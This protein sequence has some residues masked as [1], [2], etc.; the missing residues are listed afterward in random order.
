MTAKDDELNDTARRFGCPIAIAPE[1]DEPD[2][3]SLRGNPE[4]IL[5]YGNVR[6][7]T[8]RDL[9]KNKDPI[10]RIAAPIYWLHKKPRKE[11]VRDDELVIGGESYPAHAVD[12]EEIPWSFWGQVLKV[13]RVWRI[14]SVWKF[15]RKK[16][17]NRITYPEIALGA[18][19]D[20]RTV[21]VIGPPDEVRNVRLEWL[22]TREERK[23]QW[24]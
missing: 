22:A 2:G 10:L 9:W 13:W 16:Q 7:A 18:T 3:Q 14:P 12:V 8:S 24:R 1:F 6:V 4:I 11:T 15:L 23:W 20:D 17:R 21:V 19:I 5:R